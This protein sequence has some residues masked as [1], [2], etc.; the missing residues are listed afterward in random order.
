MPLGYNRPCLKLLRFAYNSLPIGYSYDRDQDNTQ[1]LKIICP[2]ML[3]MGHKNQ[4]Q[5]EG[6]IRLTRGTREL[7]EKVEKMYKAWF[8]VWRD[9]VVPKIMFQPKWYNSDKDLQE[10]DLV[11]F[12]KKESKLDQPWTIGRVE[13]VV[14]SERDD[15]IRKVIVKYQNFKEAEPRFTDRSVRKLV[16]LFNVDEHQVQEDLDEL[17][18]KIDSLSRRPGNIDDVALDLDDVHDDDNAPG[19]PVNDHGPDDDGQGGD[20]L[21]SQTPW[22]GDVAAADSDTDTNDLDFQEGDREDGDDEA[23][24]DE[25]RQY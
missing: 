18:K 2:N 12:Q 9:T 16:K 24:G 22:L 1:V 21:E 13:Q 19:V 7:M 4:R 8:Y 25:P 11:Y 5:L 23:K 14:R 3:K 6:P 20:Q 10:G 15:L 17:Q